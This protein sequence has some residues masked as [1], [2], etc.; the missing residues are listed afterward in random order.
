MPIKEPCARTHIYM[1]VCVHVQYLYVLLHK[2][3]VPKMC[4]LAK[5]TLT[6]P[7]TRAC[8]RPNHYR[9]KTKP[10]RPNIRRQDRRES[11]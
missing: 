8:A 6:Q 4:E 2:V 1:H 5:K 9:P 11:E 3:P 10:Y 7:H